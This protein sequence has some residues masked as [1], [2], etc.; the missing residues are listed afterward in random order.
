[1]TSPAFIFVMQKRPFLLLL[2]LLLSFCAL[3]LGWSLLFAQDPT[4]TID[5]LAPPPTV[6]SPGQADDGA[7]L[8]WLN[9]QPCH[10]DHGQGLTDEW[11]AQYPMEDQFCWN[12][13]CHGK[14]PYE[15][16]FT[17]PETVPAVIGENTLS[18]FVTA[19]QLYAY[20]RTAMPYEYPGALPDEEYLA[21]IAFLLRENSLGAGITLTEETV[22]DV[23]LRPLP[24]ATPTAVSA[25]INSGDTDIIAIPLILGMVGSLLF[26]GVIW[27]WRRQTH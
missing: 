10:G 11:R 21:I 6:P 24:T 27:L 12:S 9:C 25:S 5:R 16:G 1:M 20:V 3:A 18:R 15:E 23:T 2:S 13:G 7:Y 8:F 14:R 19:G 26:V 22:Y 17:L 4:P